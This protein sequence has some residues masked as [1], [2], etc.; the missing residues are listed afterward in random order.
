MGV[1]IENSM[2]VLL[3]LIKFIVLFSLYKTTL[4]MERTSFYENLCEKT[5]SS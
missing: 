1:I 4:K 5:I 2:T 3:E